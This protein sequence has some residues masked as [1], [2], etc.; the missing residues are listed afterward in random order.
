ML[1]ISRDAEAKIG[2]IIAGNVLDLEVEGG[3]GLGRLAGGGEDGEP[4]GDEFTGGD[5]HGGDGDGADEL[6]AEDVVVFDLE[7]EV[8]K[9]VGNGDL[10]VLLPLR[11]LGVGDDAG[12]GDGGLWDDDGHVRVAGDDAAVML[13]IAVTGSGIVGG[14]LGGGGAGVADGEAAA[15]A[16]GGEVH[17]G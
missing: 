8:N 15:E 14:V 17:V 1:R 4:V 12:A 3:V 2:V 6:S 10:E 16:L 13:E 5:T 11:V 7:F 9:G